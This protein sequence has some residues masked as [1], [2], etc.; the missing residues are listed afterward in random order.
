V[1]RP[2]LTDAGFPP[3]GRIF[4]V[5]SFRLRVLG[6]PH[7]WAM[8]N[9]AEIDR[10]WEREVEANPH[11]FNGSIV[12]HSD[13]TFGSGHVEGEAHIV[14]YAA[15]LHW[16]RSGRTA[17][18]YHLFGM[19]VIL[20]ADGALMAVRMAQTTANPGRV[21][22]PAGSLDIHDVRDGFCDL[23]GNMRRETM[24]ETGLDLAEMASE[25]RYR[26][27]HTLNTVAIFRVFRSRFSEEEL[28]E[29]V[30]HHI[31]SEAEPEISALV[32]IRSPDPSAHDYVPFMLPVL[33]WI[34]ATGA[35]SV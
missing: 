17:G 2:F 9:M 24:E 29:R 3:E 33:D 18:G 7:P 30:R 19:P 5:S 31:E 26:A 13:L 15:F 25:P 32:G 8:A 27:V 23:E 22:S 16:R 21:Y 10:N 14:P 4:D 34:F 12:F 28:G 1:T 6:G 11:L 35:E 20:S